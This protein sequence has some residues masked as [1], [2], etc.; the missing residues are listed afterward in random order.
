MTQGD[1]FLT[2]GEG[3]AYYR[4]NAEHNAKYCAGDDPIARALSSLDIQPK[5]IV[6][7]GCSSG[8][9]L[10]SLCHHYRADGVGV[11]PSMEAILQARE[12]D[13]RYAWVHSTIDRFDDDRWMFFDLAICSF[14]LHW[15][16]RET[17]LQ[18]LAKIEQCLTPTGYV[19]ILDFYPL[20]PYKR[21]YHHKPGVFTFKADYAGMLTATGCYEVKYKKA[22]T[23]PG[24][25]VPEQGYRG[26]LCAVTVLQRV[27]VERM[28]TQ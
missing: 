19:A 26:E 27:P 8:E 12:A 9:R 28:P 13:G 23:Y 22:L 25:Q 10:R 1:V 16:P 14:V 2:G 7:L 18:S 21:A 20:T 4:R 11:D 24:F 15:V 3:D 6:D 17:L 5:R